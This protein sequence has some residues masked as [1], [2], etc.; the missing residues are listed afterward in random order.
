DDDALRRTYFDQTIGFASVRTGL[1]HALLPELGHPLI[2]RGGT[3]DALNFAQ[4]FRDGA[5]DLP[6]RATPLRILVLGAYTGLAAVRL[7]HR[8]PRA[9]IA[10]VEPVASNHRILALNTLPYRRIRA[11]NM[12]AWHSTTRLGV[13]DRHFGDW[14]TRLGERVAG[15]RTIPAG[16]IADL[17][18]LL[19]WDQVDFITCDIMGAEQ[20]AF[21]DPGAAWLHRLDALAVIPHEGAAPGGLAI[22]AACFDP[23]RFDVQ[24]HAGTR[25][26]QRRQPLRAIIG[27]DRRDMPLISAEPGLFPIALQD[28]A[29]TGWGFFIF[30][31]SSCQ[32]HPNPP[33]ERPARAIFPRTLDDHTRFLATLLHAGQQAGPIRFS[34]I[35]QRE[36]GGEALAAHHTLPA[37]ARHDWEI[38]LPA[39]SGRHRLILQT[40]M[41]A[42]APGIANAW[43][44][45][46]APRIG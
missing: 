6:V 28:V 39:L 46:I 17:L 31:G 13:A 10:C 38:A 1:L 40:E 29:P 14:G 27:P 26:Y 30:D 32:L 5:A 23:E 41:A 33:E 11:L 3:A 4:V 12:A 8:F 16:T 21:A 20:A 7:A 37:G 24:E 15:P 42:P 18:A 25:L 19:G 2:L 22:L 34:L 45:W 9:E 43:A 44:Q 35:I 36:D